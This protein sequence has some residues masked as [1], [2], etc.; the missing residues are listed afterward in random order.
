MMNLVAIAEL[1]LELGERPEAAQPPTDHNPCARAEG[2]AIFH[3]VSGEDD[4]AIL[5]R[6]AD[7]CDH[8]PHEALVHGVHASRG[9]VHEYDR[10]L[11]DH[12]D[13]D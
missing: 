5:L 13:G 6:R 8:L 3:G 11:A 10:R 12:R 2:L 9:L 1:R 4:G 7:P